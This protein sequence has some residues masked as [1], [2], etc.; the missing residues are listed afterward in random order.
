VV[1]RHPEILKARLEVESRENVDEMTLRCEVNVGNESLAAEVTAT[2]QSVCKVRGRVA[3][4][5]PGDLPNDGKVIADLR[6]YR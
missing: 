6:S 5:R 3:L 1:A 4:V 2:V